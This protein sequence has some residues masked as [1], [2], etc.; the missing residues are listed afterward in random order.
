MVNRAFFDML[1]PRHHSCWLWFDCYDTGVLP[2]TLP[3]PRAAVLQPLLHRYHQQSQLPWPVVEA[4]A[5][6]RPNLILALPGRPQAVAY[7]VDSRQ[8]F[9]DWGEVAPPATTAQRLAERD[10]RRRFGLIRQLVQHIEGAEQPLPAIGALA[11]T[12]ATAAATSPRYNRFGVW[13][14]PIAGLHVQDAQAYA[15]QAGLRWGTVR[16]KRPR[17][18]RE[19]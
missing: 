3:H 7:T 19:D 12:L 11:D 5:G 1:L 2:H 9:T 17:R 4:L 8:F 15:A 18:G 13:F 14:Y 16:P 10:F 6:W